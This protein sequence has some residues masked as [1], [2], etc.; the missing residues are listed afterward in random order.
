MPSE[1]ELI[2]RV[3][4][5]FGLSFVIGFE[6]Q[7]RGGQAGDRTYALVGTAA[8]AVST[9]AITRSAGNAIAGVVTGVGFIGG[10]LVFRGSAGTL[11]GITSAAAVL[12]TTTIGVVAGAGY[13]LL[14]IA[15][16]AL[17]LVVLELRF[18]PVLRY[19]DAR[20]YMGRVMGDDDPP[21]PPGRHD[22]PPAAGGA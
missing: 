8:A 17:V 14:A 10:A 6:R 20:R 11:R 3:A 2:G 9:I 13:P 7:L 4:L 5:A 18:V 16:T 19:L 12:A 1:W 15:A 22:V 21:S